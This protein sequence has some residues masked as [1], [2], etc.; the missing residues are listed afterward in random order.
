MDQV[1]HADSKMTMDVYNQLQQ[2][3]KREHG[4]SFD[5]LIREARVALYGDDTPVTRDD[6]P[7]EPDATSAEQ[8]VWA[9]DWAGAPKAA[10]KTPSPRRPG[11]PQK[12]RISRN[13]VRR[14]SC[15][16]EAGG[17]R[18]SVVCSTS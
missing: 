1:G 13:K 2:R 5:R 12:P 8:G 6:T 10:R 11:H 7:V 16:L 3:A 4:A 9:G 18:F 15:N 14:G 17:P